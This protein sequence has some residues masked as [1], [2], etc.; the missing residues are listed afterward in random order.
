M[1]VLK[2]YDEEGRPYHRPGEVL[3]LEVKRLETNT[4]VVIIPVIRLGK[5]VP[6]YFERIYETAEEI[7]YVVRPRTPEE[8]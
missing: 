5:Y 8:F 4:P 2:F 7:A 6:E 3:P 1:K